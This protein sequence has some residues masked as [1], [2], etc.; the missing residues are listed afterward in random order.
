MTIVRETSQ[1]EIG[2]A[3]PSRAV[4][5]HVGRLEIAMQDVSC[6]R[7]RKPCADLPRELDALVLG[8]AA[9]PAKQR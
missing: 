6:V 8:Q 1:S 3:R 2:D 5:H 9:D 7:R 4:N